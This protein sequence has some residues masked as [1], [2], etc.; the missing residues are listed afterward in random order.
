MTVIKQAEVNM[1]TESDD[2]K[3]DTSE[4][5]MWESAIDE[6]YYTDLLRQMIFRNTASSLNSGN[7]NTGAKKQEIK[8]KTIK[9]KNNN[10]K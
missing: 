8:K 6:L 7:K 1:N 10:N 3:N 2:L 4:D 9:I 5:H